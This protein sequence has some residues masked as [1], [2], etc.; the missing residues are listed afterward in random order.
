[1]GKFDE[2]ERLFRRA[3][4]IAEATLEPDNPSR[5]IVINNLALVLESKAQYEEASGLYRE[6]LRIFTAALGPDHP[7]ALEAAR[8][9]DNCLQVQS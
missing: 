9:L 1:M 8:D 6:A 2:A 7:Y 4:N 3:L 5:A